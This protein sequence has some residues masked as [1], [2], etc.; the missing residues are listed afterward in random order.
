LRNRVK[1]ALNTYWDMKKVLS[2]YYVQNAAFFRIDNITLG[3]TFQNL[4]GA[5]TTGRVY[6]VCQ[7]PFVFTKYKGLDP[8]VAGG[9]DLDVYPRPVSFQLGLNLNF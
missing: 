5:K 9:I 6:A 7:N 8:E 3:Y 1:D 2:D 4:F